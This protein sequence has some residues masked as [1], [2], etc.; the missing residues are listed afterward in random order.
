[1]LPYLICAPH[2]A[3]VV[4][5]LLPGVTNPSLLVQDGVVE[6]VGF[7]LKNKSAI[8][9]DNLWLCLFLSDCVWKLSRAINLYLSCSDRSLSPF[10][11]SMSA[12]SNLS[13]H[14]LKLILQWTDGSYNS[15]SCWM[16]CYVVS[17]LV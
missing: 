7:L 3:P 14:S 8:Y 5:A 4:A 2:H 16:F 6:G 17:K 10:L 15:M 11:S 12:L 13:Q 1:M 9:N